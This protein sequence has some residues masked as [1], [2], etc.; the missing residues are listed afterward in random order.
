MPFPREP[1]LDQG[2][3]QARH[4]LRGQPRRTVRSAET[5]GEQLLPPSTTLGSPLGADP[6]AVGAR[7]PRPRRSLRAAA[8]AVRRPAR[9]T[10]T[11]R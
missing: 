2:S 1:S 5:Q 10:R 8:A 6:P 4:S 7:R 3:R 11:R 9:R